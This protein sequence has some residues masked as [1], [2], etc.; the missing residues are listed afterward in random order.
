M[1]LDINFQ[2]NY[3]EMWLRKQKL[4]N[5][6]NKREN[7][8][9]VEYDCKVGHYGYILRDGN[10]RKLE[11]DK[12]VPFRITQVHTN[13]SVII[14]GGIVNEQIDIQHFTPHFGDLPT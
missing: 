8:K 14:Q 13:G 6:N 9:R 11:G 7:E 4:I 3:K 12:L 1:L 10:Y 5:Y 2:Q